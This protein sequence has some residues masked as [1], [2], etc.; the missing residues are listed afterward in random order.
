MTVALQKDMG[1]HHRSPAATIELPKLHQ[2]PGKLFVQDSVRAFKVVIPIYFAVLF[3]LC[4][5][6]FFN[7]NNAHNNAVLSRPYSKFVEL[8]LTFPK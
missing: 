1:R 7:Y 5:A 2:E 8:Y 6:R 4:V 3:I